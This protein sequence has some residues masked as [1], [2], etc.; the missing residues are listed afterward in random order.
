MKNLI[1]SNQNSENNCPWKSP[2]ACC[3]GIIEIA[4]LIVRYADFG[5][6]ALALTCKIWKNYIETYDKNNIL[7]ANTQCGIQLF[8]GYRKFVSS[9]LTYVCDNSYLKNKSRNKSRNKNRNKDLNIDVIDIFFP[10]ACNSYTSQVFFAPRA[11]DEM[12]VFGI[13]CSKLNTTEKYTIIKKIANSIYVVHRNVLLSLLLNISTDTIIDFFSLFDKSFQEK[14]CASQEDKIKIIINTNF[15]NNLSTKKIVLEKLTK[16]SSKIWSFSTEEFLIKL[17]LSDDIVLWLKFD[18]E[19]NMY[20]LNE[21]LAAA[22]KYEQ[23]KCFRCLLDFHSNLNDLKF[24]LSGTIIE[25]TGDNNPYK[26]YHY[27]PRLI[28]KC[29]NIQIVR[30][31]LNWIVEHDY[32]FNTKSLNIHYLNLLVRYGHIDELDFYKDFDTGAGI[33][34]QAP[35]EKHYKMFVKLASSLREAWIPIYNYECLDYLFTSDI[36]DNKNTKTAKPFLLISP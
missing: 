7:S 31:Y 30:T 6:Y 11:F 14:L 5:R 12:Y 22:I 32:S 34:D 9:Y 3:I 13:L 10:A 27:L 4:K 26:K 18:L 8:G 33:I 19:L 25:H 28:T 20:D 36:F 17:G 15:L 35:P 29:N 23:P 1:N 2:A 16:I 24:C 21:C